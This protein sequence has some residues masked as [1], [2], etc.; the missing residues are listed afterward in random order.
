MSHSRTTRVFCWSI[1]HGASSAKRTEIYCP[2]AQVTSF[3][4]AYIA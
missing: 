2:L 1:S 4:T 3:T